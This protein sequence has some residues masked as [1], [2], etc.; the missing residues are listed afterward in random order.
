MYLAH[1]EDYVV[2]AA[3]AAAAAAWNVS[4]VRL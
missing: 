1:I 3:A 4:L 2:P